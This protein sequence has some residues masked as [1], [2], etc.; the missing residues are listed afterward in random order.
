MKILIKQF[1]KATDEIFPLKTFKVCQDDQPWVSKSLKL[2]DR[3]R[4]REFYKNHK[5]QKWEELNLEFVQKCK[6]EKENYYK[7][8]VHDLKTSNPGKWYSKVKRMAGNE[9]RSGK[10]TSE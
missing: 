8:I 3:K 10:I 2:L 9:T 7:N 1:E 4:K 6:Q 5:S